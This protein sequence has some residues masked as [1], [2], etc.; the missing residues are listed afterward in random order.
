M[1][2]NL[3]PGEAIPFSL[4]VHT[5]WCVKKCPY[6]DFNSHA[7]TEQ[8]IPQQE[9][10]D[11]LVRDLE[12]HL[13]E[14]WGRRLS[15]VFIGGGTPS[16]FA[17][18]AIAELITAI[19]TRLPCVAGMEVTLEANPGTVEAD[20]FEGFRQAGVNRLSVGVQSFDDQCLGKLGRIHSADEAVAAVSRA[21]DAGF[22]SVNLDLMFGLP[23]QSMSAALAD[24]EQALAL[25]PGHLSLYQLTIEPN[26]PF[27]HRPPEK[28]P[29]DDVL[30]EMQ[31]V[32]AGRLESAGLERYEV[33]AYAS[34]SLQCRHNRNYWEFGDYL[35]IG[36]GAHSK[37]SNAETIYRF[38]KP[39]SP[40]QYLA[41]AGQLSA[42]RGHRRLEEAD[43]RFEFMLNALRLRDGFSIGLFEGHTR[44][45]YSAISE[46]VGEAVERGLLVEHDGRIQ[47][48]ETGY[49]FLSDTLLLFS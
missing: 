4:Y 23:G 24:L 45:S 12:F 20:S 49:R 33:S 17:P 2:V 21:L 15:S 3:Q 43:L 32:L 27:M 41:E 18:E 1:S 40:G 37:L 34:G 9:Y 6:C 7:V 19:R 36:A 42:V 28:L 30:A 14:V 48:T 25:A 22:A 8:G 26:T 10:I 38:S 46:S 35:G 29:A 16:L 5:P 47:A 31:D 39:R 13:P 11:A 44:L